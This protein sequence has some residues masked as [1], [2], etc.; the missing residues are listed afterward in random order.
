MKYAKFVVAAA[1][2][3]FLSL[4]FSNVGVAASAAPEGV[5]GNK[6]A[7][8]QPGWIGEKVVVV[9]VPGWVG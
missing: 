3:G 5:V 1:A 4:T 7:L 6:I 9:T 2:V 8:A